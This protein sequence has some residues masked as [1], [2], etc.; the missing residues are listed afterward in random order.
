MS[1]RWLREGYKKVSRVVS[2]GGDPKKEKFPILEDHPA[3]QVNAIESQGSLKESIKAVK[4]KKEFKI[5]RWI[6]DHPSNKPFLQSYFLDLSTC[7][8]MVSV[9]LSLRF[10]F[11]ISITL[12]LIILRKY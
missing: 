3:A 2:K 4:K 8:P 5:Y 11:I 12:N 7:G 1:K 6:P 9:N 10:K